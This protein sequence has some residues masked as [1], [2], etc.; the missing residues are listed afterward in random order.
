MYVLY[1]LTLFLNTDNDIW[2]QKETWKRFII[3]MG[4][5]GILRAMSFRKY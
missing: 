5:N 4:Y 3:P 2:M 1:Y